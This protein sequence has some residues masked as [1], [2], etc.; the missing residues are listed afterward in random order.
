MC[1][2]EETI[3]DMSST[4][5]AL[6]FR[7]T[8][9]EIA[10]P[11]S[12]KKPSYCITRLKFIKYNDGKYCS[13]F[14]TGTGVKCRLDSSFLDDFVNAGGD[15]NI[16]HFRTDSGKIFTAS[17]GVSSW[18]YESNGVYSLLYTRS[19]SDTSLDDINTMIGSDDLAAWNIEIVPPPEAGGDIHAKNGVAIWVQQ[20]ESTNAFWTYFFADEVPGV[21]NLGAYVAKKFPPGSTLE[22]LYHTGR[23]VEDNTALAHVYGNN[24]DGVRGLT[25]GWPIV[26]IGNANEG[27]K[28]RDLNVYNVVTTA[29]KN[30]A[31]GIHFY[32]QYFVIDRFSDISS[33]AAFWANEVIT[34]N[35]NINN[36]SAPLSRTVDILTEIDGTS[37]RAVVGKSGTTGSVCTGTTTPNANSKALFH[38]KCGEKTYIGAD[39]YHFA[40]FMDGKFMPYTCKNDKTARG[41][42]NLLGFFPENACAK[43]KRGYTF[44][45][46]ENTCVT[47]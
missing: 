9:K 30:T 1:R 33:T 42:W 35:Y 22:V 41:V 47:E 45:E 11:C 28:P 8:P 36:E 27:K 13:P 31:G 16:I 21:S 17:N 38:V 34:D 44:S 7:G 25:P 43:I 24:F 5:V 23:A 18:A 6:T 39:Q 15:A 19:D 40:R 4:R 14:G 29:N 3:A 10:L 46:E 20:I 2:L 12:T 26:I 37:I 32:R